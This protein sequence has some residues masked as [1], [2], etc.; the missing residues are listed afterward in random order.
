[1]RAYFATPVALTY[2]VTLTLPLAIP[3]SLPLFLLPANAAARDRAAAGADASVAVA[4]RQDA[5][6]EAAAA[7]SRTA[8]AE[9]GPERGPEP[10]PE[11]GP[12]PGPGSTRSLP[13]TALASDR[14]S[15]TAPGM[16]LARRN[17]RQFSLL[18]VV[19]DDADAELRGTAEVRTRS[20]AT[21]AWSGWQSL[22]THNR[23][24][25]ADPGTAER[26]A[27]G[28]R[29]ATAPLWV[30]RSDGVEVRVRPTERPGRAGPS[31]LPLPHGLRL[32]L[33]DPGEDPVRHGRAGAPAEAA[34][35]EAVSAV[36]V[37]ADAVSAASVASDANSA[38]SVSAAFARPYIGPRPRIVTR[39][40]WGA[41]E[42]LRERRFGYNHTVTAAFIHHSATGNN[43]TC[44]QSASVLRAIYRYHVT[45]SGWRDFGYNFAVD[46]CG[47]IYEGRAGGIAKP[48]LG[49]HTLG[50][51]KNTVGIAVLGT[52]NG[53]KPPTAATT[54]VARLTAWKLGLH[55][56]DPRRTVTLTSAGSGKYKKGTR[57]GL[58]AIAGH[59]DGVNTDCPG[60]RLHAKLGTAR[61]K[62]AQY[63]GR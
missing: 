3:L 19:W 23:E 42:S 31:H 17:V 58:H 63:Q 24:H 1:M 15:G 43:Y 59:R 37:R 12:E 52:Y 4:L 45:S 44:R 48:V 28:V 40:G 29:G 53:T 22:R 8:P 2:T 13:L 33:V 57:V 39:G 34:P 56:I 9:L 50:F 14:L 6:R 36:S 61:D 51:N 55:G 25:G 21:R 38:A 49:A 47:T 35:A 26:A 60:S 54:A 18:G 27:A 41:D 30:G 5:G 7:A 20:A 10:G 11:R 62:A 46:K 32:D 16:G